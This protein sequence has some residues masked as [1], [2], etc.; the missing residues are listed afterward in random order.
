MPQP[1][2]ARDVPTRPQRRPSLAWWGL[3]SLLI[4]VLTGLLLSWHSL[5]DLDIWFHLRAGRDLLDG[6]GVI[7][8]NRFSFSEP[9][10]PWVNHEWMFQVLTALTGPGTLP[11]GDGLESPDVTGWNLMRSALTLLLL[12]T[13]LAGDKGV[14]RLLGRE[15]PSAAAW[16]GVPILAG[17]LLL[18]PRLTIRPELFSY[19]FFVLLVRWTEEFF[20]TAPSAPPRTAGR[21]LL[22]TVIWAQFHGFASLAP[23]VLLLGGTMA[24]IQARLFP[25]KRHPDQRG[26][27]MGR[28]TALVFLAL[29][30]LIL[31]PN[32]WNGLL[33]PIRALGQFSQSQVDLRST[34]SE[35]VPLRESPNS[36]CLTIT[37]FRV[38]LVWGLVWVIA[39]FGRVS[40]LRILVFALAAFAAWTNQRS[41]G[42]YGV[43]FMLLHTGA[44]GNPWRFSL[45][46][47]LPTLPATLIPIFGLTVTLITAGLFWPHIINDDFYLGEGIGRRFG[48]GVNPARY[49]LAAAEAMTSGESPT[50]FANLD[51]AAFLLANTSGQI[52]I[53]GRT[54]AYSPDL[55]AKYLDIKRG[56][57]K[58]LKLLADK[59]RVDAVCLATGG[60]SF[61]QLAIQLLNSSSWDLWTAE[62]A[63]LLFR[64][65][66]PTDKGDN[67]GYDQRNDHGTLLRAAARTE[68]E[69]DRGSL[70]RKA[71]ICLAAG[72][73]YMF[74]GDTEQRE[75]AFRRG[76]SFRP[77]H[78]TLNHNLG[79]LLLDSQHFHEAL[80]HFK[81]ALEKN[82]RLAGS[83]L[84]AGV[85]QMRLGNPDKA[86]GFFR[87]AA[88]IDP[89]RF[90]AWVNLSVA[91]Q[92]SGDRSGAVR[93]LEK[94]LELRPG[95]SRLQQR[96]RELM[97][98]TRN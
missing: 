98:G 57:E 33:M 32:G 7:S 86:A 66:K 12:L 95:D 73:L 25:G 77:D 42:I 17:L 34:I 54:E 87:R 1:P 60:G 52:F 76:L 23:L 9:D 26:P 67:D 13:I 93:A 71:D 90:E 84:N 78:P 27:G 59:Y 21:I 31:T 49:P 8:A 82:G 39:T 45:P 19:L 61:D 55:W 53:D 20:R 74:A 97:G 43:A 62:G 4:P 16:M 35:L 2:D 46:R 6:Q 44:G 11:P 88:D 38:S 36:L 50:Y 69:A 75:I 65:T 58:A 14:S 85:C 10:H 22:L 47:K 40:L 18:W 37:A 80:L 72:H 64:P 81:L 5:G 83:A 68:A 96:L 29:I 48:T 79:N 56:D 51:A 92:G 63:G 41:I 91:L 70:A 94:A 28:A 30:A 3:L 89:K 24:P 15:G